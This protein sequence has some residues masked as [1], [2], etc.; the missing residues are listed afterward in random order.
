MGLW[1]D[2]DEDAWQA[3]VDGDDSWFDNDCDPYESDEDWCQ[4]DSD[5]D[6]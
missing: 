6:E 5:Y 2:F 4:S 1:E 3:G